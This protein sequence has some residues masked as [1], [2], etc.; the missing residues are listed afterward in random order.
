[1]IEFMPW[2]QAGEGIVR[3]EGDEGC[4]TLL[5]SGDTE[6]HVKWHKKVEAIAAMDE[7]RRVRGKD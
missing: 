5:L 1:M 4:G 7:T 6:R 2:Y 3:C